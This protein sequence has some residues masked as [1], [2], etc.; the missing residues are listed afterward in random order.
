MLFAHVLKDPANVDVSFRYA[1]VATRMGDYEAAIGAL[2]RIIFYN[3]NL[4]RVRLELGVLY[5]RL[6]SYEMARSYFEAAMSGADTPVEV[7]TRVAGFLSEIERRLQ[8][9]QLT[10]FGQMGLRH[11]SNANAG[12]NSLNVKALGFDAVLSRQYAKRPDWNAFALGSFR[13]I[14]DFENQRGDVLEAQLTGYYARQFRITRLNT[15]LV[16]ANIGPRLALLPDALPGLSI[17][18]YLIGGAVSLGDNPYLFSGGAGVTLAIPM[19]VALIE[20][21]YE[22]RRRSFRNSDDIPNATE[23]RGRLH[24]GFVNVSGMILPELRWNM[25]GAFNRADTL[26][27]YNAYRSAAFDVALSY[28]FDPSI[29]P[30]ARK[31]TVS[32]FVGFTRTAYDDPNP[33]VDPTLHRKDREWRFGANLDAPIWTNTG[34]GLTVQYATNK[35]NIP[36]Y[37]TRNF[38]VT[39]GPTVRF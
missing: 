11:Q 39:F 9:T 31:W 18:P 27:G 25:R 7:R 13:Y 10:F 4:P 24:T 19:I 35:S 21:G 14:H 12:P 16:E 8:T 15:G 37:S 5:F 26:R 38:S 36:N 6:G 1:E 17:K 29:V 30:T 2:E 20:P 32:P 23:Q 28:E 33:V 22:I 34:L 3:P